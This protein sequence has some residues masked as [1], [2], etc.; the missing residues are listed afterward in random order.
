[1]SF[2]FKNAS[3]SELKKEY[4]RIAKE[5]GDDQFFTKKELNYLPEIL[6][7]G[8]QVLAF[9][10][11]MMDGNTWLLTLTDQRVI[12]LDKGMIFG[13][14]Q[15]VINLDRINGISC[16]TGIFFGKIAINDGA[17]TRWIENVWK[18]TVKTFTNKVQEAIAH[19]KDNRN[20]KTSAT[21]ENDI[22]SQ[23]ERLA[24]LREK[25]ILTEDEFQQQK[26]KILG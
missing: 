6:Q 14:K 17:K 22:V 12:F 5:I 24:S 18:K 25:G 2:D 7:N 23:L 19:L 21:S 16:S 20:T 8:E 11:G 9:T 3:K 4:N 15:E 1:M 13:L 26:K 10:S